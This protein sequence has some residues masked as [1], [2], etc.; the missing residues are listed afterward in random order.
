MHPTLHLIPI[1]SAHSNSPTKIHFQPF[2]VDSNS[3]NAELDNE[4]FLGQYSGT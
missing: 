1:V 2:L 3:G 4:F